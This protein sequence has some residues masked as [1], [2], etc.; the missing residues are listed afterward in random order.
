MYRIAPLVFLFLTGCANQATISTL[1]YELGYQACSDTTVTE[2]M[3]DYMII[4]TIDVIS[5]GF[6][7]GCEARKSLDD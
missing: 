1:S 2:A 5:A 7:A 6:E 4:E 3:V